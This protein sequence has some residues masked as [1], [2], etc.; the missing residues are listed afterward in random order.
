M[1]SNVIIYVEG[2]AHTV[3]SGPLDDLI[4]AVGYKNDECVVWAP[5]PTAFGVLWGQC[6][7]KGHEIVQGGQVLLVGRDEDHCNYGIS[8]VP[9]ELRGR[10]P[11][12]AAPAE[13]LRFLQRVSVGVGLGKYTDMGSLAVHLMSDGVRIQGDVTSKN[14]KRCAQAAALARRTVTKAVSTAGG[15]DAGRTRAAIVALQSIENWS[16]GDVDRE[17]GAA[18]EE[19]GIVRLTKRR[20]R[21]RVPFKE[22]SAL[23]VGQT[24]A[25]FRPTPS[26]RNKAISSGMRKGTIAFLAGP[27]RRAAGA[28][29]K[30]PDYQQ[31]YKKINAVME[32]DSMPPVWSGV[33]D[34]CNRSFTPA[35]S[36]LVDPRASGRD[37]NVVRCLDFCVMLQ[38][39]LKCADVLAVLRRILGDH[40]DALLR[41][42]DKKTG[43]TSL[44]RLKVALFTLVC[45][46]RED[47]TWV[48]DT[49]PDEDWKEIF[50]RARTTYAEGLAANSP[51]VV[52]AAN[53]VVQL[54]DEA[55]Q[56]EVVEANAETVSAAAQV[57]GEDEAA[58][59]ER[60]V[61]PRRSKRLRV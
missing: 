57:V 6:N 26:K 30:S 9:A 18:A 58:S 21:R 46:L 48:G 11:S 24:V 35:Q 27:T 54:D 55:E 56:V 42:S 31:V 45:I 3:T 36:K 19:Y 2:V 52:E 32:H 28:P 59:S 22:L 51:I 41:K 16:Q 29:G 53:E 33:F 15:G 8:R 20:Q 7:L 5:T 23:L 37:G 61:F 14:G 17:W 10:P 4:G 43:D 1:D 44:P 60:E 47:T 12:A 34:I 50:T 25:V 13:R 49:V 38:H 39:G 40:F